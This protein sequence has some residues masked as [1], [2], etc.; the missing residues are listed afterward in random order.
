MWW[1]TSFVGANVVTTQSVWDGLWL[2][3]ILQA[4]GQMQCKR[5]TASITLTPDIQAGRALTLLSILLGFIVTLLRGGVANCSGAPPDPLE[6]PTT[7]SSRKK[8]SLLGG[9]LCILC[10]VSVS[11]SVGTTISVYN[12]PSVAAALKREV[13]SSIY[14]GWSSSVLLLLGGA[15]ICFFCGEKERSQHS[16]YS[17]MPY[18]INTKLG[19]S[20]MAT[21]RSDVADQTARGCLIVIR[22][23]GCVEKHLV[24]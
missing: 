15:L 19:S 20:R 12:D 18:S 21:L 14:I 9:V 24:R 8:G 23:V 13:G 5:H 16:Y 17:Y 10:L 3:C 11:W 2:H 4:T 1:R 6:H 22:L 7:S